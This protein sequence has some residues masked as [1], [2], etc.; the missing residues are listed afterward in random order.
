MPSAEQVLTTRRARWRLPGEAWTSGRL[1]LTER[2]LAL[3]A[4]DGG[5]AMEVELSDLGDVRVLH[6]PRTVLA[7]G[8]ASGALRLRCFEAPAVARLLRLAAARLDH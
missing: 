5:T 3:I 1:R 4:P 6:R 7:L 8:P 2:R